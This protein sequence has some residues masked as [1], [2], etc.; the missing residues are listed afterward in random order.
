M[1][2]KIS[3]KVCLSCDQ[4]TSQKLHRTLQGTMERVTAS[5]YPFLTPYDSKRAKQQIRTIRSQQTD[6]KTASQGATIS[7]HLN[8]DSI[9]L[10]LLRDANKSKWIL[11]N[12][13]SVWVLVA[14]SSSWSQKWVQASGA[15]NSLACLAGEYSSTWQPHVTTFKPTLNAEY[16]YI[17][18]R[19]NAYLHIDFG[20]ES[21]ILFW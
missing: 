10:L 3:G 15:E 2:I 6:I 17:H 13:W 14:F 19:M 9:H 11:K 8:S 16:C 21:S 18:H 1:N 12:C 5:N 4:K 7:F 20:A